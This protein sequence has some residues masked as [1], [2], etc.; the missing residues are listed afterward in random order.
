MEILFIYWMMSIIIVWFSIT[1]TMEREK[2][3]EWILLFAPFYLLVLIGRTLRKY[4]DI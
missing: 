1:D 3:V 2:G 4:H